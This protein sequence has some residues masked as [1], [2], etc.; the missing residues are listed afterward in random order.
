MY[1][2]SSLRPALP[3]GRP[4]EDSFGLN[5]NEV[6][7]SLTGPEPQKFGFRLRERFLYALPVNGKE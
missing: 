2:S 4:N 6:T 5:S 1:M 7:K 3:G